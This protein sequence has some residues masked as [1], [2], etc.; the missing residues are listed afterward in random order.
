M[1]GEPRRLVTDAIDKVVKIIVAMS[2]DKKIKIIL[3]NTSGNSNRDIP[4]KPPYSQ[5]VVIT[6]LRLLLPPHADNEKAADY[7]RLQVGKNNDHIEWVAVR[8][9]GLIDEEQASQ[10]DVIASPTRNVIFNAASTSRINVAEFMSD[11]AIN[12]ELWNKWKGQMPV[13]YNRA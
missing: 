10:Y 8:P 13:I 1:F 7:L 2:S 9:D 6:L 3:M 11:L 12:S 4:E 5:R